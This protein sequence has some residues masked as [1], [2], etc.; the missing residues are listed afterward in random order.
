MKIVHI[1]TE[2]AGGAGRAAY[3]LHRALREIGVD[4]AMLVSKKHPN[5]RDVRQTSQVSDWTSYLGNLVQ[6]YY[7]DR[8]RSA[9]WN[10]HF[11]LAW[12]GVDLSDHPLVRDADV[13][14]LHW[15]WNFQS[16]ASL[17]R[18]MGLGKPVVWSF[19]DQRAFTGGCHY[20][21][22]CR[23]YET[24]CANCPQLTADP[25][26]WTAA[27]VADQARLWQRDAV[28]VIGLSTWMAD[29]A[30]KSWVWR[31]SRIEVIPNCV[32]ADIYLPQD[33]RKCRQ[34]L[35][36]PED[37]KCVLFGADHGAEIR[38]GF[39]RFLKS[40]ERCSEDPWFAAEV[41]A[42]RICFICFGNPGPEATQ[43][44][45]SIQSLGYLLNDEDLSLAYGAADFFV[46][47]S[48]EDNLPNTVLESMSCGTPVLA[49]DVGGL[50]D[51]VIEGATGWLV[52]PDDEQRLAAA[53]LQLLRGTIPTAKMA[54]SCRAHVCGHFAPGLQARRFS[55]LYAELILN[56]PAAVTGRA[57]TTHELV[58]AGWGPRSRMALPEV[59]RM[60]ASELRTEIP[61]EPSLYL[62]V[63]SALADSS[64]FDELLG[65]W[66][67]AFDPTGRKRLRQAF[68][69]FRRNLARVC[70]RK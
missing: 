54:M 70:G 45:V 15:L 68:K 31:N 1:A 42:R 10:T 69:N 27:V 40:L 24:G 17:G 44:P 59:I 22:G 49:L 37:A 5:D 28:T 3:R 29:C 36:V 63:Q 13:I 47:P 67:R 43:S 33:K 35:G 18:L 16:T 50:R 2:T 65:G 57:T 39:H 64:H 46:L 61:P 34:K 62:A 56:P 26:G 19:H 12:S 32:E 51:M 60:V 20:S 66:Q 55:D 41:A 48:I 14:H 8:H 23:Q 9:D 53:L 58:Q 52:P 21:A 6:H 30:R 38:K 25:A 4:S 11:S 7:L